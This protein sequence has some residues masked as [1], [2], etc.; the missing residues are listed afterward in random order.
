MSSSTKQIGFENQKI[1]LAMLLTEVWKDIKWS[2]EGKDENEADFQIGKVN[3]E[4]KTFVDGA[5][6]KIIVGS[7]AKTE[8]KKAVHQLLSVKSLHQKIIVTNK[9]LFMKNKKVEY[10]ID[11]KMYSFFEV[12]KK[13]KIT[14]KPN[15]RSKT[16]TYKI[17][18][19]DDI[20]VL[21]L[22]VEDGNTTRDII[23]LAFNRVKPILFSKIGTEDAL[24]VYFK[25]ATNTFKTHISENIAKN[26]VVN[27][28]RYY[29]FHTICEFNKY[30]LDNL[31][32]KKEF[33]KFNDAMKF[34]SESE[35][36]GNNEWEGNLEQMGYNQSEIK[37]FKEKSELIQRSVDILKGE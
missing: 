8:I 15:K 17:K 33:S 11:N 6:K 36:M 24:R 3:Y 7:A 5:D 20:K 23:D 34:I 37:Q 9:K 4:V 16:F 2:Y 25:T 30:D 26:E 29:L 1:I 27:P 12:F 18:E 19:L 28:M 13:Q 31:I 14:Y 35:F 10:P 21:V 22:G 32:R